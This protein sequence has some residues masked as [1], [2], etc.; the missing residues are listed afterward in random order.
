MFEVIEHTIEHT[1]PD[2]IKLLPFLF[3]TY[4]LMEFLEHKTGDG[5][6]EKIRKAGKLG[7]L[8]GGLLGVLPQCGFSISA[9]SLYAG[10]VI[11]LGTLFAVY[12]STSDEMLPVLLSEGVSVERIAKIVLV[13]LA[14][15]IVSGLVIESFYVKV[16]KKTEKEMD[17][18]IVCEKEHCRCEDGILRSAIKHTIRVFL[19]ILCFSL[20]LTFVIEG[21]GEET[22][23][24]VFSGLP[25]VGELIAALVGL[26]PNCASSIVITELYLNGIIGAGAM[27]AG[28]L[29]NA[30][31]GVL[32]LFRVN[33]HAKENLAI[34]AVL[35]GVGVFWGVIIELAGILF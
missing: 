13:K 19:Y 8:W 5:A 12:L 3:F 9:S 17:I 30:G 7:P 23:A 10:R 22:L 25:V 33:R 4:L 34:L 16:L 32:V 35:Y 15:A 31:M 24:N 20:V 29:V 1:V 2:T 28:L 26:I 14:I 18:H 6:R 11:T 27:M 21:F